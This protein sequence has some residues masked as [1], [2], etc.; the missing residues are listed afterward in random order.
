MKKVILTMLLTISIQGCNSQNKK[1]DSIVLKQIKDSD[2]RIDYVDFAI[3]LREIENL[4]NR[5]DVINENWMR[6]KTM[7]I[8]DAGNFKSKMID[9]YYLKSFV[10]EYGSSFMQQE[11]DFIETPRMSDIENINYK[12]YKAPF[13]E[14][15]GFYEMDFLFF[16]FF[17]KDDFF[18]HVAKDE[19]LIRVYN[20]MIANDAFLLNLTL[21]DT[22]LC[23][24]EEYRVKK[25]K[26][27]KE[28]FQNCKS[29]Y[30]KLFYKDLLKID[31]RDW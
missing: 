2:F 14:I 4:L 25:L 12:F 27:L 31:P 7:E 19:N 9:I 20:Q 5:D 22:L 26:F 3:N 16:A 1:N 10:K 18:L 15:V 6:Y 28:W 23:A 11:F 30:G 13:E 17:L 29:E 24:N 21:F 8:R